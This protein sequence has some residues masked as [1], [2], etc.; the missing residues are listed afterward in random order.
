[1]LCPAP[2]FAFLDVGGPEMLLVFVLVLVLFGGK[3]MPELARGLGKSLRDFKKARDG[4]EDQIKRA[5]EEAPAPAK[6]A[7]KLRSPEPATTTPDDTTIYD[8]AAK[9]AAAAAGTAAATDAS[10][11]S[12]GIAASDAI[13][14][15][16]AT[17][18]TDST[19]S[20]NSTA[21]PAASAAANGDT[22]AADNNAAAAD[23]NAS[24]TDGNT[25]GTGGNT[26][27]NDYDYVDPYEDEYI[28]GTVESNASAHGVENENASDTD[29]AEASNVSEETETQ[30]E[31]DPDAGAPEKKKD[32]A[33]DDLTDGRG[34]V[35]DGGGI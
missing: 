20:T 29:D 30:P 32:G 11:A 1:M 21:D 23:S 16:D 26:S 19:N 28:G 33:G 6:R 13:T 25:S 22:F 17:G 3:R 4:V 5:L 24:D 34:S 31:V 14:A 10:A 8:E 15:T 7:K 12:D 27:E 9:A 2:V 35:T 18:A